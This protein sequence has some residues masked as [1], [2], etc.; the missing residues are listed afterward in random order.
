MAPIEKRLIYAKCP[1]WRNMHT[2]ITNRVTA[3]IVEKK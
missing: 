1:K 2:G 3:T